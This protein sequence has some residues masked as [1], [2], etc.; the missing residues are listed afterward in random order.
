MQMASSDQRKKA[1]T[2][3]RSSGQWLP[4]KNV[5]WS[6]FLLLAMRLTRHRRD[7]G[8]SDARSGHCNCGYVSMILV[9]FVE[10][11]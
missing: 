2:A 9:F 3:W 10:E 5:R 6:G 7:I 8:L 11:L 4:V 1:L